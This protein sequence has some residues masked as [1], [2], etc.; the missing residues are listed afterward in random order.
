MDEPDSE[1]TRETI[2]YEP[3]NDETVNR[4]LRAVRGWL[5]GYRKDPNVTII[6]KPNRVEIRITQR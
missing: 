6:L 2:D 1:D 3:F 4:I 5:F